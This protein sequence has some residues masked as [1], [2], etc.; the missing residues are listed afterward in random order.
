MI[1]VSQQKQQR[2]WTQIPELQ[3]PKRSLQMFLCAY[4]ASMMSTTINKTSCPYKYGVHIHFCCILHLMHS[5]PQDSNQNKI[6]L[7]GRHLWEWNHPARMVVWD[8]TALTAVYVCMY[9]LCIW[10]KG[11]S[12]GCIWVNYRLPVMSWWCGVCVG[13]GHVQEGLVCRGVKLGEV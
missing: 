5:L 8:R 2:K 7:L 9:A 13:G 1:F 4:F 11:F 12:R 6:S 10:F 3:K